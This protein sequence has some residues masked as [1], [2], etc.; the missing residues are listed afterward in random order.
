[1]K[2]NIKK[3]LQVL[4]FIF[5]SI[6]EAAWDLQEFDLTP[7]QSN[8]RLEIDL[9]TTFGSGNV[10]GVISNVK[11]NIICSF[12]Q[13]NKTQGLI[14]MDANSVRF[15]YGKINKDAHKTPWL[16]SLKFPNI[17]FKLN[18]LENFVWKNE[19]LQANASGLLSIKQN[20]ISL[21]LPVTLHYARKERKKYDGKSGD[22]IFI[23]GNF[24]LSREI[25]SINPS[26]GLESVGDQVMIT[27]HLMAGS[28]RVRPFLPCRS[29]DSPN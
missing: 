15:G 8:N 19:V 28:G 26:N 29:F 20:R 23:R 2:I 9:K 18:S 16:H 25:L 7:F 6:T 12:Q 27:L 1:M 21:S 5:P 13:P 14:N 24:P 22:L 3:L 4:V 17:S 11:G 10:R